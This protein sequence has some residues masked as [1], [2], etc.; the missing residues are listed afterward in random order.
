MAKKHINNVTLLLKAYYEVLYERL[1]A[2]RENITMVIEKLMKEEIAKGIIGESDEDKFAAYRDACLAF[3]DERLEMYNPVGI[4]YT[5]DRT[6]AKEAFE[7]GLQLDWYDSRAESEQLTAAAQQKAE[8]GMSD[9]RMRQV[10][11]ELIKEQGAYPDRSIISAYED[12]PKPGKLP[13]YITARAIEE[14]I[15]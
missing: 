1:E 9:R 4:Q 10:A 3:V 5:F 14:V 12:L 15:R 11:A 13:D 6:R 2:N 7:L 8:Y